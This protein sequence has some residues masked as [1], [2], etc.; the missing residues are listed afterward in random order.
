LI[1]DT[2]DD[3]ARGRAF[4]LHRAMDTTGAVIG[5]LVG[6]GIYHVAHQHTRTVLV[7]ALIPA[8]ISVALVALVH[9]P[10]PVPP[11]PRPDTGAPEARTP[12]PPSFWRVMIPVGVFA[13][14][15]STDALLL[16][17]ASELGLDVTQIVLVYVLFNL[18]YATVAYPAG[19][20]ADRSGPR[21]VFT[22]GLIVFALTY[23]GLGLATS[24]AVVWVLLPFYGVFAALTDG[25]SRSWIAGTVAGPQRTWALGVHGAI[26]GL[27]V[28]AAGLWSGLTWNGTGRLPLVVSGAVALCV[29]AALSLQSI[30]FRHPHR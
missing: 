15:N 24:A 3:A 28:L 23:L 10:P 18:V 11:P 6:L 19:K 9:E 7:L 20:L 5:P 1:A 26:T 8:T 29:A 14:A 25:V 12:L 16:Q 27:A 17:R 4:G 2:V 30:Q 21:L 22:T 13:L